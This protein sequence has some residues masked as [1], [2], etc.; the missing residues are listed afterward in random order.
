M[1]KSSRHAV[2]VGAFVIA[3]AGLVIA[4]SQ[5][6]EL[7]LTEASAREFVLNEIKSPAPGRGSAIVVAGT[8]AFLKLPPSARGPA[9]T[10]LFAWAKAY[11]NSAA[12]NASYASFRKSRIPQG[13]QYA[14]SVDAQVKKDIAEQLAG[15]EGMRQT[16]EKLPPKDRDLIMEQVKQ[17]LA[18]LRDPAYADKLRAQLTAERAQESGREGEVAR[19]VEIQTPADARQLF[20]RRLREFL[21]ATADVNFSARTIAL[22]GGPDGI[23]FMDKAD[24]ARPWMW[25]AAAIVGRE[26]TLAAREAAQAWLKEIE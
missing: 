25:Q 12:F 14:L 18:N 7:G 22:T 8:R 4:Q 19:E 13:R 10:A 9:A 5:L 17:A 23:E 1:T 11:A 15:F 16:A 2:A 20:A 26:A 3:M 21:G 6:A 24:R